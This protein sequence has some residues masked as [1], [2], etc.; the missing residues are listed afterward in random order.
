MFLEID[1][2][3]KACICE[4][5]SLLLKTVLAEGDNSLDKQ[6]QA[7]LL[8]KIRQVG[9]KLTEAILKTRGSQDLPAFAQPLYKRLLSSIEFLDTLKENSKESFDGHGAAPA[10]DLA[11]YDDLRTSLVRKRDLLTSHI[12]SF[13][14]TPYFSVHTL[15]EALL[16]A[17]SYTR[18]ET[19]KEVI[20]ARRL[21]Y[22]FAD[23]E[24]RGLLHK[25]SNE[26]LYKYVHI[27][28]DCSDD[29]IRKNLLAIR[30]GFKGDLTKATAWKYM[31][32][33][34]DFIRRFN[35]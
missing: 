8:S 9:L 3:I 24:N 20:V 5:V 35:I 7:E 32:E 29:Y 16:E 28:V 4:G 30:D 21:A 11:F 31:D 34:R 18:R 13:L 12:P 15:R 10:I 17:E 14:Y 6:N 26:F 19:D 33:A 25:V 2:R 27:Y 1:K 23:L 22:V